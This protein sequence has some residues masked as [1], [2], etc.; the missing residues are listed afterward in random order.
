MEERSAISSRHHN[1]YL[2][3]LTALFAIEFAALAFHPYDR[4]DWL[5]ENVLVVPAV[6]YFALTYRSFPLSRVSLT[7]IFIFLCLHEVGAHYTYAEVPYNAWTEALFGS[8]FNE[9]V[10]WKR[11]NFDRVVHFL[12]G[13]L[14]AYPMREM[15]LR[16]A[17]G[18]GFWGYFFPLLVTMASSMLYELVEWGAAEYFGGGL[19]IAYLGTQG[20]IWDA[21]KDMMLASVG[22]LAAMLITAAIN[23]YLKKD[24]AREWAESLRIKH[25]HPLGEDEIFRLLKRR[26]EKDV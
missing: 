2:L 21:H 24:F 26:E 6:L 22:A 17:D 20:D 12:Y 25:L 7:L 4:H 15:F 23:M 1:R 10:G 8:S 14:L 19:G 13:L 5:L 3:V 16:V 9:L 11:N 18:R